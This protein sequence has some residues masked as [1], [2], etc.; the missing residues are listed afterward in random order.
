L[1]GNGL[2]LRT[3]NSI[4]RG[5]AINR[6]LHFAI[7]VSHGS[8]GNRIVGNFLG[9]DSTGTRSFLDLY[10]HIVDGIFVT[11][12]NPGPTNDN[13]GIQHL[14]VRVGVGANNNVIGGS[15]PV[16]RNI[17]SGLEAGVSINVGFNNRVQGNLIGVAADGSS[18]L[19]N[20]VGILEYYHN[21]TV[22][23]E[24]NLDT[25]VIGGIL[26][27]EGNVIA[28]NWR[29]G[30]ENRSGKHV[31]AV[32]HSIIRGNSFFNN[33][34]L[35][36][37]ITRLY[38]DT[39]LNG[40]TRYGPAIA[41]VQSTGIR[42]Y[43]W[44]VN[45]PLDTDGT[46]NHP[47][48]HSVATS[49]RSS[50]IEGTLESEP[51]SAFS[52]D[53]YTSPAN[54]DLRFEEGKTYLGTT[55]ATTNSEGDASFSFSMDQQLAPGQLITATATGR[56][57]SM[58]S[59]R[60]MVGDILASPFIVNTTDDI[61]NGICDLSHCSLREAIHAA[62]NH[63][64]KDQIH[65]AIDNG[66]Q[67]IAV[68]LA[69]E[70][71]PVLEPV[72]IDGTTQPGFS[73]SPII[74]LTG[75]D[76]DE[77][78]PSPLYGLRFYGGDSTIRGLV[79]NG[80]DNGIF[81]PF[82]W[83]LRRAN[84]DG[85]FSHPGAYQ[86]EGNYIGL[87]LAGDTAVP[88][89]DAG[90]YLYTSDNII[91]GTTPE[92]RNIISGN[93][94][95]IKI[96][97]K[98]AR[99]EIPTG[100]GSQ[101]LGNYIGTDPSGNLAIGNRAGI[102]FEAL[103]NVTADIGFVGHVIGG[104]ESG[105]GNLISGNQVGIN[106]LAGTGHSI[107]GNFIGTNADGTSALGNSYAGIGLNYGD[108]KSGSGDVLIGGAD[109]AARNIISASNTGVAVRTSPNNDIHVQIQGNYIGTDV[110]GTLGLAN[111]Y[112]IQLQGNGHVVGGAAP[113][114]GNLISANKFGIW[115]ARDNHQILGNLMG[116]TADGLG[117]LGDDEGSPGT[118]IL[119]YNRSA[120]SGITIGGTEPG[121]G[122]VIANFSG[123][124][125]SC[126]S[127]SG[128]TILGNSIHSNGEHGIDLGADG[129]VPANDPGDDDVGVNNLQ[130]YPDISTANLAAGAIT[131]SGSL[132]SMPETTYRVEFFSNRVVDD[133]ETDPGYGEGEHFLGAASVT[134][135]GTGNGTFSVNFQA[136]PG[137]FISATATDP[138]GN[139]SEFARTVAIT[140]TTNAPPIAQ[141]DNVVTPQ[142]T[143]ITIDI[144]A[145]DEDPDGDLDPA[146]VVITSD[147]S[148][149][150]TEVNL[151]TGA[152]IY[153]PT[154][155]FSGDDS[156]NYTVQDTLGAVSNIA[157]VSVTV[158]PPSNSP[159]IANAGVDTTG[160][161][162]NTIQLDGSDSSD[163]DND[164]LTFSWSLTQQPEGSAANLSNPATS[165]PS[166]VPDKRGDYTAQLIVNDSVVNSPPDTV[167]IQV[168]NTPPVADAGPDQTVLTG[169]APILDGSGSSDADSDQLSYVWTLISKPA[170]SAASL[171]NTTAINPTL[172]IDIKGTYV[173]RLVVNDGFANSAP[174]TVT[175]ST[176]NT[177]PVAD[178][179]PDQD[180]LV[181]ELIT[182]DGSGSSDVDGDALTYSWLLLSAPS[183]S[184][185]T[186][187]AA[188]DISPTITVDLKGAYVVEL[189][190]NDGSIDSP[191]DTLVISIANT[192]PLAD[193]GSDQLVAPGDTAT[194]DGSGSTDA[195]GDALTYLW[196]ITAQ[197]AGSVAT[198]SD[199]NAV[200]PTIFV[201]ELGVYTIKLVVND[202]VTDSTPDEVDLRSVNVA[203]VADAGPDQ[204]VVVGQS[205]QLDGSSSSDA[206]GDALTYS[207]SIIDRP[208]GS[209]VTLSDASS[210]MP[211]LDIDVF[212][213]YTLQLAVNDGIEDSEPDTVLLNV[214]NTL[215]V[216]DAGSD[217]SVFVGETV[218]LDGS[219]SSDADGNPL[220]FSWS[221]TQKPATSLSVLMDETTVSPIIVI[222]EQGIYVIQLIINDGIEDSL[223]DTVLLNVGNIRPV[224]DA[225]ADQ[226]VTAPTTVTLDGSGSSDAD[227]D[228]LTYNW[229]IIN[230]P[231]GSTSVFPN[232]GV[233]DPK[234]D[235]DLEGNYILQL[236]VND[237]TID[238]DTD[239][240]IVNATQS[241]QDADGDGV[242]DDHDICENT[243]IPES[244]V[245]SKR[246][247][248]NRWALIDN[249]NIFDTTPPK[250]VGPDAY[251]TT[252]DTHGCSCE[253]IIERRQLGKGHTAFGCSLGVMRTWVAGGL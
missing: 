131:V 134:T 30:V 190:V 125:I 4:I 104:V 155:L 106:M 174:D 250:G 144:L 227:K 40:R 214:V 93:D 124:G 245:P 196:T 224:A 76:G 24:P 73:I 52:I 105:A 217:Q 48:L 68:S 100:G 17:L 88:N 151:S 233:V 50:V 60:F 253:Q 79:I 242:L 123:D 146:K 138:D 35:H 96:N 113:G 15:R 181:D 237:G 27:G 85:F 86:I 66:P 58:F 231:D 149:G 14:A 70:L 173:A 6:V 81:A 115:I 83:G 98:D 20:L 247:G 153:T 95:G 56:Y 10:Q 54:D 140:G 230:A 97:P 215:P 31:N 111:F 136:Q 12:D 78:T 13:F 38:G 238:S 92:Q 26:P 62:N 141:G 170:G 213:T 193:A 198:L 101:I 33:G 165:T 75:D 248:I 172:A 159:P 197:P 112:G 218:V 147:P 72:V 226:E 89:E 158:L 164:A 154:S 223:P 130:N 160:V 25:T 11:A 234:L 67:T 82:S 42:D 23:T 137:Q 87:N 222:D 200:M 205:V 71:P 109:T 1:I 116:T 201:D 189:T 178:A 47:V 45:L 16:D 119:C 244:I 243:V 166:L 118:G 229:S 55:L 43:N 65:F 2:K 132:S 207:W 61:D 117:A 53:I 252:D 182:L 219:G 239:N 232:P 39:H 7:D 3:N 143:P 110:T 74:E 180:G 220:T 240:V 36:E 161:V 167:L 211:T 34:P 212:G 249:D 126:E 5:L 210:A 103:G 186:L 228:P 216:A 135:D 127:G 188:S 203:P 192:A 209:V 128:I 121:S 187:S 163:P 37:H 18:P 80:F 107:Q 19:P 162:G 175:L 114:E 148:N 90:I 171:S 22:P 59:T 32:T 177:P 156:F 120:P 142:A 99:G 206:D 94:F 251:F 179:G 46:Q 185:A 194:L 91:G 235:I 157:T 57:S 183:E 139:T 29:Y 51:G 49:F 184:T 64:G 41:F 84:A 152:V 122:N 129:L 176:G 69:R 168:L 8:M 225:G 150:T 21:R 195:D 236:I 28:H 77:A 191:A 221:L 145:N 204:S 169:D 102:T 108:T 208:E 44:P 63:P 241:T 9:T 246:L 199:L 133:T 202:S